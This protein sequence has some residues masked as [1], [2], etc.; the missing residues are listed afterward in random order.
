MIELNC[1]L[2]LAALRWQTCYQVDAEL[3]IDA[4]FAADGLR[5]MLEHGFAEHGSNNDLWEAINE[6][7]AFGDS[8]G[9]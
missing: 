4:K 3:W 1:L 9:S 6:Q 8:L 2:F 5:A 7:S